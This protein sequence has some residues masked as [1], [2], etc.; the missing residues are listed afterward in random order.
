M[1]L[2]ITKTADIVVNVHLLV[3]SHFPN[4]TA[5]ASFREMNSSVSASTSIKSRAFWWIWQTAREFRRSCV[6]VLRSHVFNLRSALKLRPAS[7]DEADE[8]RSRRTSFSTSLYL[9]RS[10]S[11]GHILQD[12]DRIT[13]RFDRPLSPKKLNLD[14]KIYPIDI[15]IYRWIGSDIA[16]FPTQQHILQG[17]VLE[18]TRT[19]MET[20]PQLLY[21]SV[22]K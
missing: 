9:P 19:D 3:C 6:I 12:I 18:E 15:F 11:V 8:M 1:Y 17:L 22:N 13:K 5:R 20:F 10:S 14:L 4:I 7:A 16:T 2:L 21:C